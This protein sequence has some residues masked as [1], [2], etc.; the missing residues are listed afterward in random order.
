MLREGKRRMEFSELVDIDQLQKLCDS[1]A[2]HTGAV[3]AILDLKGN[4]LIATGWQDICTKFHR[5]HPATAKRCLESDTVL[6]DCLGKGASYNI[7]KCRNGLVD[8]A[9]PILI[10]GIHVANFFTGQFFFEEPDQELFIRQAEEFGFDKNTYLNA[11]ASVPI[12]TEDHVK[13]VMN[14][15]SLLARLFG[16]MGLARKRIE[17]KNDELESKV[18]IRTQEMVDVNQELKD[19]NQEMIA[20]NE[21]LQNVNQSLEEE[22]EERQRVERALQQSKKELETKVIERTSE[23]Y[24]MNQQLQQ[25]LSERN[26]AENELKFS[27][28]LLTTQQEVSLDGILNVD[29]E[30]NISSINQRFIDI[31]NIPAELIVERKDEPL[32][33]YVTGQLADPEGFL[34]K[35]QHLYQSRNETSRDEVVLKDGRILDRYS[36][37]IFGNEGQYYGRV[38]FFR[39]ITEL[40]RAEAALRNVNEKLE[41]KVEFRTAEVM[42]VNQEL[43]TANLELIKLNEELHTA[44]ESLI[45][46]EKMTV[47]TRLVAGMAHEI[48]TPVGICVTLAS[49]LDYITNAFKEIYHAGAVQRHDLEEYIA[50]CSEAC[51][52]LL[53]NTGRAATLV[54]NFKQ[55]SADQASEVRRIFNVCSYI[56]EILSMLNGKIKKSGH[57][58]NVQCDETINIDGYPGAF[59]QILTN[60]ILNSLIHAYGPKDIGRIDIQLKTDKQ[61]LIITY[62]DNGRGMDKEVRGKI[63]DPF[64]TTRRNQGGTGL[65]MCIVYNLVTQLYEGSIECLSQLGVGTTFIITIP[66]RLSKRLS[67]K[68]K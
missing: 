39:E 6:A 50:E 40:R 51:H 26:R 7:Y 9:V 21:S 59:A 12:L 19:M 65:G 8:V 18:V 24:T 37:P 61:W 55:V 2:T 68:E 56:G 46:S 49:H 66:R 38:W 30:N 54:T 36:A 22:I 27:N 10:D 20:M 57:V 52:M 34:A 15:F 3:M 63:F 23:L 42:A 45:R 5:I 32:L 60:L 16:E 67:N 14:F 28:V 25:E 43:T 53:L 48:N 33:K 13:Q 17:E 58:V 62:N 41:R 47:L 64:F 11:L 35:V 4:I 44:Q 1:Y 29:E 31:W